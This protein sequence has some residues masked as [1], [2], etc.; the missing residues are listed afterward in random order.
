MRI[1]IALDE[2]LRDEAQRITGMTRRAGLIREALIDVLTGFLSE[3]DEAR[4]GRRSYDRQEGCAAL[5]ND[6]GNTI[7]RVTPSGKP[8]IAQVN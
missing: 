4:G 5:A 7:W 2:A 1:T 6:V 8:N 3:D